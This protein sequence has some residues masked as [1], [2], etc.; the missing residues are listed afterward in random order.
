MV[1]VQRKSE[2][3]V[4]ALRKIWQKSESIK[5]QDYQHQN[6]PAQTPDLPPKSRPRKLKGTV[7]V[8][9][10]PLSQV[11]GNLDLMQILN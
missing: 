10:L 11:R 6:A 3:S 2:V 8:D 7:S 9:G 1:N 5:K 4:Q